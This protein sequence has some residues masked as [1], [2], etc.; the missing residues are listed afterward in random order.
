MNLDKEYAG[1]WE[2]ICYLDA[3]KAKIDSEGYKPDQMADYKPQLQLE[4]D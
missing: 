4:A 3:L 2:L 1:L